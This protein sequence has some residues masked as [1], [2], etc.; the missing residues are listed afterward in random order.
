MDTCY[1]FYI[2]SKWAAMG[3]CTYMS[4]YTYRGLIYLQ[5]V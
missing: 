1:D 5:V 2:M 3:G 4:S